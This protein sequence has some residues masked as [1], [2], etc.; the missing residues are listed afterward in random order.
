VLRVSVGPGVLRWPPRAGVTVATK[1]VL[2]APKCVLV[3]PSCVTAGPKCVSVAPKCVAVA[4]AKPRAQNTK[5]KGL[6]AV[7]GR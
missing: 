4:T 6:G 2:V 1:S 7:D 3:A 5:R